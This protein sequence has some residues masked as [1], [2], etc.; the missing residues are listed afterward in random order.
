MFFYLYISLR[1][2][3]QRPTALK[4]EE[5]KLHLALKLNFASRS[6]LAFPEIF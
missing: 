2:E 6:V 4:L 1:N 5:F 3:G